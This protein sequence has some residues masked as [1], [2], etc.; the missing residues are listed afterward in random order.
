MISLVGIVIIM[1]DMQYT[2]PKFASVTTTQW[3]RV[4]F[5]LDIYLIHLLYFIKFGLMQPGT[6]VSQSLKGILERSIQCTC[7]TDIVLSYT[8]V[9]Q[10]HPI[11]ELLKD[12][13]TVNIQY[14]YLL[15]STTVCIWQTEDRNRNIV[16]RCKLNYL[17][18]RTQ[19]WKIICL[20]IVSGSV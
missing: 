5:G 14:F 4:E 9:T 6:I 16:K 1:F 20:G 11:K 10:G 2:F 12:K 19:I 18:T 3:L 13:T 15:L 17:F 7:I 8:Q